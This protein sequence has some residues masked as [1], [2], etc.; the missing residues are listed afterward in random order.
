M[1]AQELATNALKGDVRAAARL[2]RI[3]DDRHP[4]Y[5]D[6]MRLIWP[7][8]GR[9]K[10]IGIT[11]APGAGKSTIT[12]A[13]I[14]SY[15][16][17]GQTVGVVAIDPS[18]PFSGGAILG[19]RIR[20]ATHST[21]EAVFIRSVG[22]RGHLG[23][24]SVS[25]MDIAAVMDAMGKDIVIIETVGVGQDEVEIASVA[26]CSIVVTVPG[27]GDDIQA[28]KAGILEIADI[29]VVNK[30]DRDGAE[31]TANDLEMMLQLAPHKNVAD[32]WHTPIIKTVAVNNTGI[33][34]LREKATQFLATNTTNK[35]NARL[36]YAAQGI[37][38]ERIFGKYFTNE[39]L[40]AA[41]AVELDP[42]KAV[43][44]LWEKM[45]L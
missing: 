37:V 30:A 40:N 7:H 6:C 19:D 26:D 21:D 41:I 9:A 23:G 2:M 39:K 13:L 18:S 3:V 45:G 27:L 29:F 33:D 12:D 31:R 14:S 35:K 28:I 42:Y 24:M 15:R 17:Q 1:N 36:L 11:G 16:A 44:T 43:D 5:S 4:S 22:T 32:G 20:M 10:I 25:A 38:K 8:T 34:D